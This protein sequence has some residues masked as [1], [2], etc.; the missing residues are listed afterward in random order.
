MCQSYYIGP[1][2]F[3]SDASKQAAAVVTGALVAAL[4]HPCTCDTFLAC[5]TVAVPL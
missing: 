1:L 3:P 2:H 4:V 5:S